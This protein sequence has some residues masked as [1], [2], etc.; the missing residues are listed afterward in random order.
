M[1]NGINTAQVQL[2]FRQTWPLPAQGE[3]LLGALASFSPGNPAFLPSSSSGPLP[4]LP[5]ENLLVSFPLEIWGGQEGNPFLVLPSPHP[6][7]AIF[8]LSPG[9]P[10]LLLSA[11][12]AFTKEAAGEGFSI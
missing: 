7:K 11:S 9:A 10:L 2:P 5:T 1:G 3:A 4:Y 8:L 6:G 12:P